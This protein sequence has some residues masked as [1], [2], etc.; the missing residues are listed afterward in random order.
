MILLKEKDHIAARV[1]S[2]EKDHIYTKENKDTRKTQDTGLELNL[3]RTTT[4]LSF[5]LFKFV[6]PL[7]WR[8]QVRES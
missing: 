4:K 1:P 3:C 5:K 8:P 6:C 7:I 2:K